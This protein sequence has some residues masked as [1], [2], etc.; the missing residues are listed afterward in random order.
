MNRE[1]IISTSMFNLSNEMITFPNLYALKWIIEN[2]QTTFK[3]KDTGWNVLPVVAWVDVLQGRDANVN[4]DSLL[5]YAGV[6]MI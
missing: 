3:A 5:Q 6:S 4:V 2:T 1:E